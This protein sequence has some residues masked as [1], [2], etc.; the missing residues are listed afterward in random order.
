MHGNDNVKFRIVITL[1]E[2]RK[3]ESGSDEKED[4]VISIM[5]QFFLKIS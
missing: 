4:L 5:S 3:R 2:R 1:V